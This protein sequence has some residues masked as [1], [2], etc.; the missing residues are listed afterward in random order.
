VIA[1]Q[2]FRFVAV[3]AAATLVHYVVALVLE[4]SGA[5]GPMTA[6]LAGFLVAFVVSFLG[7]WRWTFREADAPLARA[8]PS[9]FAVSL[10]SFG[11]NALLLK[12]LLTWGVLPYAVA[13]AVVLL[14]VAMGTFLLSRVWAFRSR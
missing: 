3:G 2:S 5:L 8:L 6:N 11:L 13:L 9:Y 10:G 1:R 12:L 14:L 4:G 7:Q